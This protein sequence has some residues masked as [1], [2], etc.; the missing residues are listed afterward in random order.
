M[1]AMRPIREYDVLAL[2]NGGRFP[3]DT[4]GYV[5]MDGP[6]YLGHML[7]RVDGGVT[8]VLE[9]GVE[10]PPLIDGAVRACVAAGQNAGAQAFCV[11]GA[12]ARLAQWQAVF[13]PGAAQPVPNGTLFGGC[14]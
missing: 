2:L 3:D 6:S 13:A 14:E 10:Q 11:N 5:V 12:D 1:I 8:F 4:E 9:C 7:Y